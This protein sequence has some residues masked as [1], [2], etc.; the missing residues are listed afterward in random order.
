MQTYTQIFQIWSSRPPALARG[1]ICKS[2]ITMNVV[3]PAL[4]QESIM[5]RRTN[6]ELAK[7]EL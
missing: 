7:S 6:E 4:I 2:G 1:H 5:L 3:E